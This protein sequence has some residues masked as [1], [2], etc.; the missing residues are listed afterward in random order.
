[1]LSCP[2]HAFHAPNLI[3]LLSMSGEFIIKGN[4]LSPTHFLKIC[5]YSGTLA[6]ELNSFWKAVWKPNL[7]PPPPRNHVN[8]INPFQTHTW[9]RFNLLFFKIFSQFFSPLPP[10]TT[11]TPPRPSPHYCLCSLVMSPLAH[12]FP[13]PLALLPPTPWD[14]SVCSMPPCLWIYFAHQFIMFIRFHL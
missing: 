11:R 6:L 7:T 14:I 2:C 10:P 8:G 1:M 12:L 5:K 13:Y 3:G 9:F 4:S